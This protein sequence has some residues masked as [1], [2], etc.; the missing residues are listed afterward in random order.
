MKNAIMRGRSLRTVS[1]HGIWEAKWLKPGKEALPNPSP[2]ITTC[3]PM[4]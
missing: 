4:S 1:S 2:A 3:I